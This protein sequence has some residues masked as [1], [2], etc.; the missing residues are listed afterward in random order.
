MVS[1]SIALLPPSGGCFAT[2][3]SEPPECGSG[4]SGRASPAP[5][6]PRASPC[7]GL[8]SSDARSHGASRSGRFILPGL[9]MN[10]QSCGTER[11]ERGKERERKKEEGGEERET[12]RVAI[13]HPH[14]VS[15]T[16]EQC[17]IDYGVIHRSAPPSGSVAT[18]PPS[19]Q[20]QAWKIKRGAR[21]RPTIVY[22]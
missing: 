16:L 10:L 4:G 14:F 9:R 13:T 5:P 1:S 6:A 7:V 2:S 20:R 8:L 18:M 19:G 17:I 11:G 22:Y 21:Q 12:Q 15:T 3:K